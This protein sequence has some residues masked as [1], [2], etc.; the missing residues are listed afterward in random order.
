MAPA[1]RTA[2]VKRKRKGPATRHTK[3]PNGFGQLPSDEL[4]E[5]ARAKQ[6][7]NTLSAAAATQH[8][9]APQRTA[10]HRSANGPGAFSQQQGARASRMVYIRDGAILER[11]VPRRGAR[12][13][14]AGAAEAVPMRADRPSPRPLAALLQAR[15]SSSGRRTVRAS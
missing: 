5:R 2:G 9:S 8:R 11:C 7:K 1:L 3:R 14:P 10:A 6:T 13:R 15:C 12:S 4:R